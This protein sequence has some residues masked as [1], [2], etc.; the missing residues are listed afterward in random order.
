LE[1]V[2]SY[3]VAC[4]S[5]QVFGDNPEQFNAANINYNAII[6]GRIIYKLISSYLPRTVSG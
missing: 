3:T 1:K 2:Y 4:L 5:V 6:Y